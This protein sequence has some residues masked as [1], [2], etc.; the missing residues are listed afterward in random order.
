MHK[1]INL[2]LKTILFIGLLI[3]TCQPVEKEITTKAPRNVKVP[4]YLRN[5]VAEALPNEGLNVWVPTGL[6]RESQL[7]RVPRFPRDIPSS[8]D[9]NLTL[10]GVRNEQISAQLAVASTDSIDNLFASVSDLIS[11]SG[12]RISAENFQVRFVKY[13]PVVS[14]PIAWGAKVKDVAGRGLS[15]DRNPDVVGDPLLETKSVS[16]PKCRAQPIWF[17][18]RIPKATKPENYRGSIAISANNCE[19]IHYNLNL[20]INHIVIPDSKNY[21]FHLDVWLNYNAIAEIYGL[22]PWSEEHWDLIKEYL[23]DLASRGQKVI[24]TTII[25]EP[26]QINWFGWRSQTEIGY[27]SMVKWHYDGVNWFFDY[28]I[29]DRCV[30][31]AMEQGIDS[32]IG[33]YSMLVF[34]GKQ[35]LTYYDEQKGK[36]IVEKVGVGSDRWKEVWTAFLKDFTSHLRKKGWL[37]KTAISFDERPPE[38]MEEAY[39]L[40]KKVAP[41][42]AYHLRVAGS[43]EVSDYSYDLSVYYE[44]LLEKEYAPEKIKETLK[45][46]KREGKITTFYIC[47]MPPHPNNFV[48]SPSIESQMLPWIS[49]KYKLDGFLRWAY[50]SWPKDVFKSPVFRYVEGDEY[51][52]Y[53][54]IKGPM[55]SIRW[56]LLKEGIEDYELISKL[57]RK[58][59]GEDNRALQHAIELATRNP[60]G[61]KKEISD[62]IQAR[63][64]VVKELLKISE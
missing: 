24:G 15:G 3:L 43:T 64:I 60:D 32:W 10:E 18:F 63:D 19:P 37:N 26:W 35:R 34:R 25:E 7:V 52:V 20:K 31:S 21:K 40:I 48:F 41:E 4:F 11:E 49:A 29:F 51:Q 2:S 6:F 36:V 58:L 9:R 17:T 8:E 1:R 62:L 22:Q 12:A 55:S 44:Y 61:R 56:E 14:N 39:K 23:K 46:R 5:R 59:G 33:A 13:M 47:G 53:P 28:S 42:L 57:R 16:V 54:G 50:C 45:D 27:E 30:E 38:Q